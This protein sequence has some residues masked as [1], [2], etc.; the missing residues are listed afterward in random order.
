M[1]TFLNKQ[2]LEMALKIGRAICILFCVPHIILGVVLWHYNFIIP[3]MVSYFISAM[4]IIV[5]KAVRKDNINVIAFAI[6]I[7]CILYASS[8]SV[9]FGWDFGAEY[10]LLP[11]IAFCYVG[12]YKSSKIVY[13]IAF[14]QTLTFELLYYL[15]EVKH[16]GFGY[17]FIV[18]S[19]TLDEIFYIGH[20]F[21]ATT[22]IFLAM[23][24]LR[25]R[26]TISIKD[27]EQT[28]SLLEYNASVDSLTALL[29]RRAFN[30]K[31]KEQKNVN[32]FCFA[33]IDIDFF[34]KINDNYGHNAGDEV[35]KVCATLLNKNF[36]DDIV[37]RWGGEEF[38]I[39]AKAND[40]ESF[41]KKC[42]DFRQEFANY[43]F[44]QGQF[45]CTVSIGAGVFN[46]FFVYDDFDKYIQLID[47]SLYYVKNNGKNKVLIK[48]YEYKN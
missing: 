43:P 37:C 28:N 41:L 29:N 44:Y 21:I 36:S 31:I 5:S 23:Y 42:E 47:N 15:I 16:L 32:G 25:I 26:L 20:S 11:C 9:Y 38:V 8:M 45:L 27:K 34:K 40:K 39:F 4:Y 35:L 2:D 1:G 30:E 7:A 10:F 18:N 13:F 19:K 33:I 22:I 24:L 48:E 14:V 6:H 3:A 17:N 46:V 12:D